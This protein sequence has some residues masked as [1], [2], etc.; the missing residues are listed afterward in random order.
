MANEKTQSFS[1]AVN[2]GGDSVAI[3]CTQP[4]DMTGIQMVNQTQ[5]ITTAGTLALD[6][7]SVT[8][9]RATLVVKNLDSTNY[10]D[11]GYASGVASPAATIPPLDFAK[12]TVPSGVTTIYGKA[13]TAS[14]LIAILAADA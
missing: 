4:K 1:T 5:T 13:N 7:G 11:I 12:L 8:A 2:K 14:V 6:I 10:L 9:A 3:S